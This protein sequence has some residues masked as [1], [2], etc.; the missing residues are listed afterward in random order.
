MTDA[1]D[2]AERLWRLAPHSAKPTD[3]ILIEDASFTIKHQAEEISSLR[4]YITTAPPP[5]SL[6]AQDGLVEA[7]TR[8]MPTNINLANKNVD[9]REILPLDVTFGGLRAISAALSAIKGD[10][11]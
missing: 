11:S 4:D 3:A 9:D 10:K 6:A 2:I 8:F 5:P 7:V 1:L